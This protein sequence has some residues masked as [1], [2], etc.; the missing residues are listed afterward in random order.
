MKIEA[1]E[2]RRL[3]MP[4]VSPFRSAAG[5]Q[6]ERDVLVVRMITAEADGWGECVAMNEPLYSPEYTKGAAVAIRDHLL[7]RLFAAGDVEA[8]GVA[9]TLQAVKGHF[10]AKAALE[11]AALDA[12]LRA[13][14]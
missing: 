1:V 2:L 3:R 7:P 8:A 6:S 14:N 5:A 13:R 12:E 4:L 9:A 11:A 10:M